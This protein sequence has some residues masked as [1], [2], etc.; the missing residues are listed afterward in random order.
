MRDKQSYCSVLIDD[1]NRR[2]VA[3]MHFN[4]KSVKYLGLFLNDDNSEEKVEINSLTDIFNYADKLKATAS[5]FVI[6]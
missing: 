5:K 3:R 1:N 6:N 2:P 4:T